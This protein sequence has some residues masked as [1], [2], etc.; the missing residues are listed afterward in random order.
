MEI[1]HVRVACSKEFYP[2]PALI[3]GVSHYVSIA[4]GEDNCSRD[5]VYFYKYGNKIGFFIEKLKDLYNLRFKGDKIKFDYMTLYPTRKKDGL[6]PNMQ[7]LAERLSREINLPYKQILRRNRD[8]MPSHELKTFKERIKN[9][10]NSID[11]TDNVKD[12][13]IIILDNTNTTGISLIDAANLLLSKGAR[14]TACMCLGLSAKEKDKDWSDL[15]KTLK[16]SRIKD[17]CRN[18]FV[19][20]EVYEKWKKASQN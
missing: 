11:I 8:I 14:E 3:F 1:Y 6:N 7:A 15:N 4:S 9:V 17:I 2:K 13:S 12:K 19:P 5:L 10:G 16:Y 20:Q 18:P